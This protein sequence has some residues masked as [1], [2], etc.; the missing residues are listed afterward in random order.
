MAKR[1]GNNEGS[2][3]RRPNGTWR[4]Q[5]S[6]GDR[7]LTKTFKTRRECQ[8]WVRKTLNQIDQGLTFRGANTRLG[9]FL[10]KWLTSVKPSLRASTWI[11]Y[12]STIRL[13]ILPALGENTRLKDIKPERLQELYD[14]LLEQGTGANTVQYVH[15][16]VRIA[17]KHAVSLGLI[18]SNPTAG[19]IPPN[20]SSQEMQFY[21]PSQVNQL[22]FAAS[23]HR[24]EAL[25]YL[26]VTTGMRQS[27]I[28]GLR[29]TDLDWINRM[30][31][32]DRQLSQSREQYKLVELKTR[33]SR[34]T[35]ELG[36]TTLARIRAHLDQQ[37]IERQY[38]HDRWTDTGLIFTSTVGTPLDHRHVQRQFKLLTQLAGLPAIR[39]HDLRHTAASLMLNY[40]H[41]VI[42]V[43]R[44]LGHSKPSIT[45]DMYGHL[46][47]GGHGEIAASMNGLVTSI[48]IDLQK[49][50]PIEPD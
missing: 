39:F 5:V 6:L 21:T 13:H 22:L 48:A 29:W 38:A 43:S 1:R 9:A 31:H 24:L 35:I 7:R 27:E 41:P 37:N 42:L 11:H 10:R 36:E 14:N 16:V 30:L 28:L 26:A 34:R 46:M 3:S 33:Y 20:P 45:M 47:P 50:S 49:L 17:L 19:T 40:G 44:V 2:I 23:G 32:I 25:F 12:E 15:I 8:D 4:G 18:L